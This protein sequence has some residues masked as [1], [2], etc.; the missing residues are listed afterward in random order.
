MKQRRS[1]TVPS[2][3]LSCELPCNHEC[4]YH[5][6]HYYLKAPSRCIL[7]R[8]RKGFVGVQASPRLWLERRHVEEAVLYYDD[9]S[10]ESCSSLTVCQRHQR[11]IL[12]I[13][14]FCSLLSPSPRAIRRENLYA[15]YRMLTLCPPLCILQ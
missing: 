12:V 11:A 14:S 8:F 13:V 9:Y 15:I 1:A 7:A 2:T 4:Y 10:A 6:I 5:T 3:H